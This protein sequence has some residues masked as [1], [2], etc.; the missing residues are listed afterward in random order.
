MGV[1]FVLQTE[2]FYDC[3]GKNKAEAFM[4]LKV[5][6][7]NKNKHGVSKWE[8]KLSI[9]LSYKVT[10]HLP[11]AEVHQKCLELWQL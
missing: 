10:E 2:L 5:Q 4:N 3:R 7:E 11:H 9:I 8:C 1:L 6:N